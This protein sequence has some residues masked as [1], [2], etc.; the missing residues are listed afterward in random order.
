MVCRYGS[1]APPI[2]AFSVLVWTQLATLHYSQCFC[3]CW[4]NSHSLHSEGM[5]FAL[6]ILNN[7]NNNFFFKKVPFYHLFGKQKECQ[8]SPNQ[9]YICCPPQNIYLYNYNI[10]MISPFGGIIIY[11]K[12][13]HLSSLQFTTVSS[14]CPNPIFDLFID[15]NNHL[16][17]IYGSIHVCQWCWLLRGELQSPLLHCQHLAW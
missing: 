5:P 16:Y 11:N 12:L 7:N 9:H 2:Q 3:H 4:W 8:K 1:S 17:F 13:F 6:Y 10:S 15:C 14:R